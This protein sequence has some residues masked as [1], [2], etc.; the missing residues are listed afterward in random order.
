MFTPLLLLLSERER[1]RESERD[2]E[3]QQ[4]DRQQTERQIN[5][6]KSLFACVYNNR[7][8]K[9]YK[10]CFNICCNSCVKNCNHAPEVVY[11]YIH[12]WSYML[13]PLLPKSSI[14]GCGRGSRAEQSIIIYR[15][16]C[17]TLDSILIGYND[18]IPSAKLVARISKDAVYMY[19]DKDR[20]RI[21][22]CRW[23]SRGWRRSS[24]LQS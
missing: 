7:E 17:R 6:D 20:W 11:T 15:S 21:G 19:T 24:L 9:I 3:R 1:E 13:L 12:A 23:A 8:I 16:V 4:I 5:T 10:F 18:D 14:R 22:G 2:R